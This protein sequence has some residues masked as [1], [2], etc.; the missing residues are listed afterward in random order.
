MKEIIKGLGEF[1]RKLAPQM[2]KKD[3]VEEASNLYMELNSSILPMYETI[4]PNISK[5][6]INKDL[7]HEVK[8]AKFRT[9]KDFVQTVQKALT[10]IADQEDDVIAMVEKVVGREVNKG[11]MDYRQV[12][13]LYYLNGLAWF[14][15]YA[16]NAIQCIVVEEL[17]GKMDVVSPVDKAAYQEIMDITAMKSFTR[18]LDILTMKVSQ[19]ESRLKHL[20]GYLFDPYEYDTISR[21]AIAKIDPMN[22][23][24]IPVDF[25]PVYLVG[26]LINAWSA[27]RHDKRKEELAKLQMMVICLRDLASNTMDEAQKKSLEEQIK[28]HSNRIN[29]ISAKIEAVEEEVRNV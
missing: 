13:T 24:L 27:N 7:M 20:D 18:L 6:Q 8:K 21:T 12:N 22:L 3:I 17:K 29:K 25:N 2:G 16:S 15:E 5:N 10:I 28:Y 26:K 11:A 4:M 1:A 14:L 19:F 23:G 9:E